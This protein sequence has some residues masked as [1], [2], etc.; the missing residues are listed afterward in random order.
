MNIHPPCLA[1]SS[2]SSS[3]IFSRL[4]VLSAM[5]PSPSNP[6][7][8]HSIH[9]EAESAAT[10]G[11]LQFYSCLW[12]R[13]NASQR[14]HQASLGS[15]Y[16]YATFFNICFSCCIQFPRGRILVKYLEIRHTGEVYMR[17]VVII[18]SFIWMDGFSRKH[19]CVACPVSLR[20]VIHFIEL[21]HASLVELFSEESLG[22][23]APLL[24]NLETNFQKR[25]C[26]ASH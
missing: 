19:I 8:L 22:T 18:D 21:N 12:I 26:N 2:S 17:R 3:F 10:L 11:H 5:S 6:L 20:E 13:R 16:R 4:F 14:P 1:P 7:H 25:Q 24:G 23:H 9:I 15:H